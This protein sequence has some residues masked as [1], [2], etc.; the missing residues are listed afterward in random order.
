MCGINCIFDPSRRLPEKATRVSYM[1][2]QMVYRGPDDGGVYNDDQVALGMRRL[3]IIDVSGGRQPLY[4]EDR[5]LV[6]ICNGEIYNYLEL[7]DELKRRGHGFR[8][9]SDTEVLVRGQRAGLRVAE[10]PV[11]W[12]TGRTTTVRLKDVFEMGGAILSLWWQ[13]HGP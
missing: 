3:S 10:F 1:N 12:R 6:L 9:T 4:N 7:R 5:S 8:T 11:S 13:L 2:D